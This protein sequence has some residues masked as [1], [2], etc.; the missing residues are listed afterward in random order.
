M[1]KTLRAIVGLFLSNFFQSSIFD[2]YFIPFQLYLFIN[3]LIFETLSGF[4]LISPSF[5]ATAATY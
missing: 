3:V 1:Y 5:N 2:K 4:H